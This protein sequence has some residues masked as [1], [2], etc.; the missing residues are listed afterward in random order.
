MLRQRQWPMLHL[1]H[2]HQQRWS[3]S[4][5]EPLRNSQTHGPMTDNYP[6]RM[7]CL[8]KSQGLRCPPTP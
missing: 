3:Q 6:T 5:P 1:T 7:A 4:E 2:P 8:V